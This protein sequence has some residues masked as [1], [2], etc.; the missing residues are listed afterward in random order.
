[1][2]WF[3]RKILL[4]PSVIVQSTVWCHCSLDIQCL[5]CQLHLKLSPIIWWLTWSLQ[6][7]S[8]FPFESQWNSFLPQE[9]EHHTLSTEHFVHGRS[10]AVR[11]FYLHQEFSRMEGKSRVKKCLASKSNW[12]EPHLCGWKRQTE[13]VFAKGFSFCHCHNLQ[14]QS[15][16]GSSPSLSPSINLWEHVNNWQLQQAKS[17]HSLK[18]QGCCVDL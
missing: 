18:L 4:D 17:V 3:K 13:W 15:N 11:C 5:G 9:L 2:K 10:Y 1:M 8:I 6:V 12:Q 7:A 16:T 14:K